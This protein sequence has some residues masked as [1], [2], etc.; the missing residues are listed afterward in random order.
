[1]WRFCQR[2]AAYQA[3]PPLPGVCMVLLEALV[4]NLGQAIGWRIWA[5]AKLLKVWASL[6]WSDLQAIMPAELTFV[7]V[8]SLQS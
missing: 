3:G 7:R 2:G 4:V 5:W 1:M 6:R 8:A